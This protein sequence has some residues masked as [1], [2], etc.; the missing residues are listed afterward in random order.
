MKRT[1]YHAGAPCQ[2]LQSTGDSTIWISLTP[3]FLKQNPANEIRRQTRTRLTPLY[4][5][6]FARQTLPHNFGEARIRKLG[7]D[8]QPW[9]TRLAPGVPG[10]HGVESYP[11]R[12]SKKWRAP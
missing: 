12:R 4:P 2:D 5:D 11:A 1:S 7:S 10:W 8:S 6:A 3:V 9:A